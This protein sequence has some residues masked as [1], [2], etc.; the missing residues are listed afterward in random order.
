[1]AE[2]PVNSA[3]GCDA[4]AKNEKTHRPVASSAVG[5]LT[6][7]LVSSYTIAVASLPLPEDTRAQ[8]LQRQEICVA[9]WEL[10]RMRRN[11]KV[12]T[13]TCQPKNLS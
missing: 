8:Q 2:I 7:R 11:S 1:V 13:Q 10:N 3:V 9:L 6:A 4:A 5:C 12:Q